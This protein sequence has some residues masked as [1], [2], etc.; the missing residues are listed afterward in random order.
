MIADSKTKSKNRCGGCVLNIVLEV[1][2]GIDILCQASNAGQIE[3]VRLLLEKG[4]DPNIK[5]ASF[6]ISKMYN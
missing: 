4:T 3:V 1:P 5:G 2:E 6:A